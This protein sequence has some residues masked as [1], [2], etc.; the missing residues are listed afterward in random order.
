MPSAAERREHDV[1]ARALLAVEAAAAD[2]LR[3]TLDSLPRDP[4]DAEQEARDRLTTVFLA[5]RRAAR[6]QGRRRLEAEL[7]QTLAE[8]RRSGVRSS[9]GLTVLARPEASDLQ[10]AQDAAVWV[11]SELRR[12][13]EADGVRRAVAASARR[14]NASAQVLTADA[15]ADER[16]RVLRASAREQSGS[17][18]LPLLGRLWDARLDACPVCR[19]LDGTIRPIGVGFPGD[20][21][22]GQAHAGCR[23]FAPLLFAPIYLGR[24]A[25]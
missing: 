20:A 21:V 16:D 10:A 25:A 24:S 15:W 19:R 3:D 8:A 11:A 17:D 9:F 22:A 2:A 5:A 13:A 1:S 12:R 14:L 4:A 23:C 6:S 18:V 7:E